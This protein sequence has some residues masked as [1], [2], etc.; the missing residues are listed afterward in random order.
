MQLFKTIRCFLP[1]SA[2]AAATEMA[3]AKTAEAS[4][5]AK[6]TAAA[7]AK[8]ARSWHENDM[9]VGAAV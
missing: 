2:C 3:S 8:A 6:A 7:T 1:A 9:P 5:S 4:A